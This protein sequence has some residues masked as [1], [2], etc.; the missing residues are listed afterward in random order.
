MEGYR[1]FTRRLMKSDLHPAPDVAKENLDPDR[2]IYASAARY[3]GYE[4]DHDVGAAQFACH[5]PIDGGALGGFCDILGGAVEFYEPRDLVAEDTAD[6]SPVVRSLS[7]LTGCSVLQP[8]GASLSGYKFVN[9]RQG[10]TDDVL[11][12]LDFGEAFLV[13][14]APLRQ[15]DAAQREDAEV[16]I[17]F[18]LDVFDRQL[19]GNYSRS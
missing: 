15:L 5:F 13:V 8:P 17:S 18:A 12:R 10:S 11:I 4:F 14:N 9:I 7:F 16:S 3:F 1:D 19:A 2:T 6:G